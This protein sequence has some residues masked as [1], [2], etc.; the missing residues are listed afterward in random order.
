MSTK[1]RAWAMEQTTNDP[2]LKL[3]LLT[4]ADFADDEG[5][6]WPGKRLLA[7]LCEVHERSVVR[8]VRRLQDMGLLAVEQRRLENGALASNAFRFPMVARQLGLLAETPMAACHP[9]HGAAAITPM[10]QLSHPPG[11]TGVTS[12]EPPIEPP[13]EPSKEGHLFSPAP[14]WLPT[15]EWQAFLRLRKAKR[16]PMTKDAE[17]LI[18]QKLAVWRELGHDVATILKT[19]VERGWTTVY[20]PKSDRAETKSSAS[21]YDRNR[22]VVEAFKRK[23]AE[24]PNP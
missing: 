11:G 14:E 23:H 17:R 5:Y 22:E 20:E 18:L 3:L 7:K 4:I 24:E 16:A 2:A 15:E 10:T 1:A 6:S 9:P 8:Y 21:L 13:K 19:S 12:I